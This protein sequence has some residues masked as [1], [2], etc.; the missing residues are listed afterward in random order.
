MYF[1]YFSCFLLPWLDILIVYFLCIIYAGL[2]V[3]SICYLQFFPPPYDIDGTYTL[4]SASLFPV[5]LLLI[6]NNK[7][8][9][10]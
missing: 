8:K 1:F 7:K 5:I 9:K 3:A 10:K 6:S 2:T 4:S